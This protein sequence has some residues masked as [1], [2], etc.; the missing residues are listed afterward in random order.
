VLPQLPPTF[1][2]ASGDSGLCPDSSRELFT[3][4]E[5]DLIYGKREQRWVDSARRRPGFNVD[6]FKP[7]EFRLLH[8]NQS[9]PHLDDIRVRPPLGFCTG[10]G[11]RWRLS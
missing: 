7:R 9:M 4:R 1:Y 11:R 10:K 3:S 8:L 5:I 2:T 6:I